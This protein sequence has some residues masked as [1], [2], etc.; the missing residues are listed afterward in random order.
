MSKL[1]TFD[2]EI[3]HEGGGVVLGHDTG[4]VVANFSHEY[5][6]E[7]FCNVANQ[8]LYAAA[9]QA[10]CEPVA[11]TSEASL[12]TLE[13]GREA[14]AGRKN[15]LRIHALYTIPPD[16]QAKIAEL[17]AT[18]ESRKNQIIELLHKVDGLEA[19]LKQQV[20]EC[21]RLNKLLEE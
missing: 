5:E 7:S 2:E 20:L 14:I 1:M 19:Q 15:N 13:S 9:P 12:Q 8:G 17:E 18:I 3:V 11:W 10:E 21:Q 4:R 6:A 16:A